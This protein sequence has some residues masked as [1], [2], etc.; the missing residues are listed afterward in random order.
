MREAAMDP[1]GKN[2]P[3]NILSFLIPIVGLVLY[4]V[5]KDA[6]PIRARSVGISALVGVVASIVAAVLWYFL[7]LGF[8]GHALRSYD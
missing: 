4:L 8:L 2:I 1:D 7:A 5:L 3:L 6:T